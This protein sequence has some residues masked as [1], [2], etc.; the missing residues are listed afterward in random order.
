MTGNSD[1]LNAIVR[2]ER[3]GAVVFKPLAAVDVT[4]PCLAVCNTIVFM[5]VN[6]RTR[7]AIANAKHGS[8][9]ISE[10]QQTGLCVN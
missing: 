3:G 5:L 4:T 9:T 7:S 10:R 2:A 8:M 6:G 1:T